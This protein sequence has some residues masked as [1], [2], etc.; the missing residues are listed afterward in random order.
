MK[1]D[2]S[3]KLRSIEDMLVE[4]KN[5]SE[6][7]VDLAYS[8]LLFNSKEIAEELSHLEDFFDKFHIDFELAVLN[9]EDEL[10]NPET[11]LGLIRI[12]VAS[13]NIA[14]AAAFIA[15]IVLRGIEP[16]PVLKLVFEQAEETITRCCLGKDSPLVGKTIGE[17]A[18][19]DEIGMRIIAV[20]RAKKWYYNPPD[21]FKLKERDALIVRGFLQ[22]R[23]ALS[24]LAQEDVC[25]AE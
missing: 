24:Q 1:S 21:S 3:K 19:D 17:A 13:E 6:L 25:E 7:M 18:L 20:R 8:A 16:H 4:M 11:K 23:E 14:D 10:I 12:G 2:K 5:T 15:D 22:G 9:V